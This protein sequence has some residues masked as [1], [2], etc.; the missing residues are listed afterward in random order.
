MVELE[1]IL[2]S[3]PPKLIIWLVPHLTLVY[4]MVK[5]VLR[6]RSIALIGMLVDN[7]KAE[8]PQSRIRLRYPPRTCQRDAAQGR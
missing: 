1:V 4:K 5:F 8:V 7:P 6:M 2:L 3:S